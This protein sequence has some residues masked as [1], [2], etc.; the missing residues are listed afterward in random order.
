MNSKE[1][2]RTH[3][4]IEP[5]EY[6]TTTTKKIR[7]VNNK[8]LCAKCVIEKCGKIQYE[9]TFFLLALYATQ[10]NGRNRDLVISSVA[11]RIRVYKFLFGV[12]QSFS[13]V[14]FSRPYNMQSFLCKQKSGRQRG[15]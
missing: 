13:R 10:S 2:L 1:S 7:Q 6:I 9:N 15:R 5:N 8:I 14:Y 12:W 4:E 11:Q 3:G